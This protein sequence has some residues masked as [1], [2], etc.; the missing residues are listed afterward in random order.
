MNRK[1]AEKNITDQELANAIID[2][3]QEIKGKEIVKIDLQKTGNAI[4]D[5]FIICQ[6]DSTTHVNAIAENIEKT[7]WEQNKVYPHHVEGKENGLWVLLD[8]YNVI[9]HVFQQEYRNFYKLEDLWADG[10]IEKIKE[11]VK[12]TA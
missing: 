3:I 1:K 2:A 6:A 9:V 4:C 11:P 10:K 5:F 8:F 7:L 12:V